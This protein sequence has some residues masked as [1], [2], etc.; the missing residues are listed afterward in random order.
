MNNSIHIIGNAHLDPIWLWRW[1]EGCGEVLQT[2]RSAVDRLNEYDGFIF[3]CS[4]ASYYKWV[5]EID[6]E[7]FDEITKLV[8][9]GRWVPVNG[10]WV[11]PDCNMPGTEGFA[12]QA[13]YS[14]LY[15]YEKFGKICEV[16]YNVDSFGHNA[17]MPQ[18][19][20]KSGMRCYVMMRP[21]MHENPDIPED[22]FWW[23]SADGSRV[24]TFRISDSY[25][26]SGTKSLD[27]EVTNARKRAENDGHGMMIFCGVGNHGGGPTKGDLDYLLKLKNEGYD[28]LKFS[29][30]DRYFEEMCADRL[31]LPVWSDE[32]QHHASGCYSATSMVKQ[33]N[34]RAE[35]W[36][37][38]AEKWNTIAALTTDLPAATEKFAEAWRDVCFNQFHDILCGCSIMEAYDDVRDSMGGAMTVAAKEENKALLKLSLNIDTWL[39]GVSDSVTCHERHHCRNLRFPRPI[40]VFNPLA[41][42][43]ESPVRTYH[44]SKRV[45]DSDGNDALFQNVRSSRSN[46]SHLDTEFIAKVP[47]LGYAVYWLWHEDSEFVE[48][49]ELQSPVAADVLTIENEYLRVTFDDKNGGISS[50]VSKEDGHEYVGG[51]FCVPAIF[52]NTKPDTWAHMIFRFHDEIAKPELASIELVECGAARAVVRVKHVYNGSY[53]TQDFILA[54][55]SKVIRVKCRILWQE[56]LTILKMPVTVAGSDPISTYEI[57]AGFIKR[58]CNGEEEPALTWGDVTAEGYGVSLISDAKYSYDCPDG[59]LRLTMLRNCIFAD[60]YSNRPAADFSYTDEG[61]QRFEYAIYPH[62][63]AAEASEVQQEAD[64]L[65]QKLVAVPVGYHKG[66]LP[67]KKSF[68]SVNKPN[69]SLSALKFCEDGSGDVIIR[70]CETA[71]KP[72]KAAIVCDAANAGFY[73]DFG[74]QEVKTFRIDKDGFVKETDFLEGVTEE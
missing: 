52:D 22:L 58:P 35:F 19:L 68:I 70:L 16:G 47:A 34:R 51:E 55:D 14:Q 41:H 28:E 6:P 1:Q 54:A 62:K 3:T 37:R 57:P 71:G 10:W 73:A 36:L 8:K 5:E 24:L 43:V 72:V 32:L 48:A 18:L 61:L 45:V 63:G 50:L 44:P 53:L 69:I 12:R 46:D 60:H 66:A 21:G 49:P 33:L 27:R 9:K 40:V 59:T 20:T 17:M 42:D 2:F 64:K 31:D 65:N 25:G 11:Q 29:S 67:R 56:P 23:D 15:Y 7:L 30:P 26:A 38:S 13:L 74:R 39:D 4:S